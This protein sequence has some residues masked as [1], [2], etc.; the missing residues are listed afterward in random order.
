MHFCR[1]RFSSSITRFMTNAHIDR[2][3]VTL[4]RNEIIITKML[5]DA[6]WLIKRKIINMFIYWRS[7][8]RR[9]S[10][11]G[12]AHFR[13]SLRNTCAEEPLNS[14]MSM[15]KSAYGLYIFFL[16]FSSDTLSYSMKLTF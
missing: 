15:C 9:R 3:S 2:L 16:T 11:Q 7:L 4:S 6:A 14:K 10:S 12:F 5:N 1:G 13:F 8:I